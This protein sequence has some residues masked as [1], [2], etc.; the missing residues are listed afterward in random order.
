MYGLT[1]SNIR[2][3][4]YDYANNIGVEYPKNWDTEKKAGEDWYA[5]FHKRHPKLSLRIPEQFSAYRI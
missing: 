3:L 1:I 2:V 5:C 4:A